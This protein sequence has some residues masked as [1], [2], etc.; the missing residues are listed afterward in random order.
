MSWFPQRSPS[1]VWLIGLWICILE[2]KKKKTTKKPLRWFC[3]TWLDR[4][5]KDHNSVITTS[6]LK[7]LARMVFNLYI[8]VCYS[9]IHSFSKNLMSPCYMAEPQIRGYKIGD[10]HGP[11]LMHL[12]AWRKVTY[13]KGNCS[14]QCEFGW[15]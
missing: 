4:H 5:S 3:Y 10:N 13:I 2:K 1:W 14:S 15:K 9:F 12:E 6:G 11:A 8:N 7:P